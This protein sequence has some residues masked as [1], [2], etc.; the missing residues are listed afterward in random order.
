MSIENLAT[1]IL[2]GSQPTLTRRHFL[3]T[4]AIA[5]GGLVVSSWIVPES[6]WASGKASESYTPNAF[7]TIN[8]DESIVL[9]MAKVEMGQGIYTAMSQLIAEELEID[10]DKVLLRHAPPDA[11]A[12][13]MPFGD[14]FTGG[15]LTIRTLAKPM[16]EIGAATRIVL[17]QAAA[18]VWKV[19]PQS[20]YAEKGEVVHTD[21]KRR[22]KYGRLVK[23]ASAIPAPNEIPLKPA[24][25]FKL[26]GKPIKRLDAKGKVDG[27]ALYGIDA[28]VPTMKFAS[29]VHSPV[30]GGR[31]KSVDDSKT[32]S[33]PG[34]RRVVKLE[35]AV[36]VVADN[37]WYARQGIA[38]LVIE[39]EGGENANLV[40]QDIR[41]LMRAALDKPGAV[42]RNDGDANKLIADDPQRFEKI[43]FNP[44]LAHAA[45]EPLNCTIHV[46]NNAAEMW[47]GTQAPTRSQA[48]VAK[49]LGLSKEQVTVHNFLLGGGFGRRLET[50]W[51]EQA[52]AIGKQVD[53]PVKVIWPREEDIQHDLF[54]GFYAHR[55]SA[56]LDKDG[57]PHAL[58]HKISGPSNI[59]RWAPGWMKDDGVDIDT[60]EGSVQF[61]YDI[62]NMRT[63][64]TIENGPITT[65]FWRGVGP[66][67][68]MLVLESF[69]DELAVNAGKDPLAYRLALLTQNKR[70]HHVLS[71]AAE[72]AGWG[73]AMPAR[74]GRGIALMHSWDTYLAQVVDLSVSPSGDVSV[75]RVV[76]VVDCG[77]VINPDTVIA[78]MQGGINFGLSAALFGKITIQGGRAVESNFHDYRTVRIN[79]SP[80]YVVE[81]VDSTEPSGGIGEPGTAGIAPALVNAI[82]AAT[83]KRI[84]ELPIDPQMLKA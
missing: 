33:L 32:L 35:N 75:Q 20:C 16:R 24:S 9:T 43:Y 57:Y 1:D 44:L 73:S 14:Q 38:A 12:Y 78:Q 2:S 48:A 4:S 62:P 5:G 41:E 67:R 31:L 68:N 65:G 23:L 18:Q 42:A 82:F 37:T 25:E 26:I 52:A 34:V 19:S 69:M 11:K 8:P 54:R 30:F 17:I 80:T 60:T 46:K 79:E 84:Y 55:V 50:D 27:S 10:L 3:T 6:V 59:Q 74:N 28:L 81:I 21:T 64:H 56:S 39:W 70:A 53:G 77:L 13:G 66:T 45:M 15:S 63:E 83:G 71:R 49:V 7:I 76:C 36:A 29:V 40:T 51:I 58:S 47:T 22:I 72:L 61:V